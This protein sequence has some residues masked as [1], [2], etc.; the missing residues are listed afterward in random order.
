M[1]K[2]KFPSNTVPSVVYFLYFV[3][4]QRSWKY[5]EVDDSRKFTSLLCSSVS[6][7][8]AGKCDLS[9]VFEVFSYPAMVFL[10]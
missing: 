10:A 9:H 4:L 7:L 1:I 6:F 5:S 3:Q 8:I 2:T